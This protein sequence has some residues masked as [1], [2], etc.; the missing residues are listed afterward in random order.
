M[1]I[2]KSINQIS[3]IRYT[4]KNILAL[5][6]ILTNTIEIKKIKVFLDKDILNIVISMDES[7]IL[8]NKLDMTLQK[9]EAILIEEFRIRGK[10][11]NLFILKK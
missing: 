4:D 2:I 11:V 5:I 9:I 8:L 1:Q 6:S 3:G 10:E 7:N